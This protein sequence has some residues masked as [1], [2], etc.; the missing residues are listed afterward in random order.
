MEFQPLWSVQASRLGALR[1][2]LAST[3]GTL[4]PSSRVSALMALLR[5]EASTNVHRGLKAHMD[6]G[7][8]TRVLGVQ[9]LPSTRGL[10]PRSAASIC[11]SN[12][13]F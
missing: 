7:A 10:S 13:G 11:H 8:L 3:V 6:V 5:G 2:P 12:L 4:D 9:D 1:C